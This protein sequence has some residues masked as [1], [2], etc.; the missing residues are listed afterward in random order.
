MGPYTNIVSNV[1]TPLI[2]VKKTQWPIYKAIYR[3]FNSIYN[4]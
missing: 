1:T 3:A 4:W 2:G